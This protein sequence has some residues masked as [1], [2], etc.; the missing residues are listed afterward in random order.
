[1]KKQDLKLIS[2]FIDDK[3]PKQELNFAKVVDGAIIA[4]DTRKVI[5]FYFKELDGAGGLIHKKLLKGFESTLGKDEFIHFENGYLFTSDVKLNI[6]TGYFV[7]DEDGKNKLG[8]KYG[9]YPNT[10]TALSMKLQHHFTLESI[11]DLQLELAQ[12]DCYIHDA[13]LNAMIAHNDGNVYEIQYKPQT[14]DADERIETATVRI[15]AKNTD[16]D[17]VVFTQYVA[18]IMGREFESKAKQEF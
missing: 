8:A 17:G 14:V 16:D 3:N 10:S 1:M 18:V 13:H 5:Q 9:A 6:D 4:T 2:A 15:V 12:R 11:D 7:E